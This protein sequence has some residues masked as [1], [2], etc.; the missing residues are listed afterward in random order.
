MRT[1]AARC[2]INSSRWGALHLKT[3]I[4][5]SG[6]SGGASAWMS[7]EEGMGG[8]SHCFRLPS[9][10]IEGLTLPSSLFDQVDFMTAIAI[11]ETGRPPA[12]LAEAFGDYTAQFR[13]MLG[14]GA[15]THRF[16]VQA[17]ELPEDPSAFAGTIVTGSAAGVYEDL[18]WIAPL[19]AW[20]RDARGKTRLVGVCF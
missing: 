19:S 5:T 1:R 15:I 6:S 2:S 8:S 4:R 9:T 14:E 16:D 20:L 17:G 13:A 7:A 11:L 12:P 18:P 10:A 3:L